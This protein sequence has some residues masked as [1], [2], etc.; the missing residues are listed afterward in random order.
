MSDKNQINQLLTTYR[1]GLD[2]ILNSPEKQVP[3]FGNR[4]LSKEAKRL[5]GFQ[6]Q[7][8]SI[9]AKDYQT[10]LSFL[11]SRGASDQSAT[12]LAVQLAKIA[13][14][15]KVSIQTVLTQVGN[16][17]IMLS[18]QAFDLL[19][20]NIRP[21]SQFKSLTP[22]NKPRFMTV[23]ES[24]TPT[25]LEPIWCNIFGFG[26]V[27]VYVDYELY[28]V[29]TTLTTNN[30]IQITDFPPHLGTITLVGDEVVGNLIH[31]EDQYITK[32]KLIVVP[33]FNGAANT[34]WRV[35]SNDLEINNQADTDNHAF[36]IG[37][38]IVE[39]DGG[40]EESPT[41]TKE[42]NFVWPYIGSQPI[43]GTTPTQL[44]PASILNL[45]NNNSNL[46]VVYFDFEAKLPPSFILETEVS[47]LM[48]PPSPMYFV[49]SGEGGA[50]MVVG[51]NT[52]MPSWFVEGNPLW[53][54]YDP[55]PNESRAEL[56]F[57][58]ETWPSSYNYYA[59]WYDAYEGEI[60]YIAETESSTPWPMVMR[61]AWCMS[62]DYNVPGLQPVTVQYPYHAPFVW[63]QETDA[64]S[65]VTNTFTATTVP[66]GQYWQEINV[67][68]GT[69]L[70]APNEP[71]PDNVTECY[72][73]GTISK[74]ADS[75]K[76]MYL[77]M[78]YGDPDPPVEEDVV[79]QWQFAGEAYNYEV[80]GIPYECLE[81]GNMLVWYN[82]SNYV[83]FYY[84]EDYGEWYYAY[85]GQPYLYSTQVF[86]GWEG[87]NVDNITSPVGDPVDTEVI[88]I[89]QT[90]RYVVFIDPEDP[91]QP[92]DYAGIYTEPFASGPIYW[93]ELRDQETDA[94]IGRWELDYLDTDLLW[95]VSGDGITEEYLDND[96]KP[97]VMTGSTYLGGT[98]VF[99]AVNMIA[100]AGV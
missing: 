62:I 48:P 1:T 56:Y 7:V 24:M 86:S 26:R 72:F 18:N 83:L 92:V 52:D 57:G 8:G 14:Q 44:T 38:G 5:L 53:R 64:F 73:D 54:V 47:D 31:N 71:Y 29:A 87:S 20:D 100:Q 11:K 78:E 49:D 27:S 21:E 46:N 66:V 82:S 15:L 16:D 58:T 69:L 63:E 98:P 25:E 89:D 67:T 19:N 93:F 43:T 30:F 61:Q 90:Y 36:G 77:A 33:Q 99:T 4:L 84:V 12:A 32:L 10:A 88:W 45:T 75:T 96:S 81:S 34:P 13:K 37:Q 6:K 95:L 68:S 28:S 60:V 51:L 97:L 40:V 74:G 41:L 9:S 94:F 3:G 55:G 76:I 59:P 91:L 17:T 80:S 85:Q 35:T 39:F 42:D 65:I 23:Y 22:I 50:R 79:I 70:E 2:K